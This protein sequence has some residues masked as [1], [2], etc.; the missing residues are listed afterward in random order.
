MDHRARLVRENPLTGGVSAEVTA[1]EVLRPDG[2]VVKLIVRRHGAVDLARNPNMAADEFRLLRLVRAHGVSAPDAHYVDDRCDLFP[3]P[4]IVIDYVEGDTVFD[5]VDPVAFAEQAAAELVKIHQIDSSADLAFLQ[6]ATMEVEA[7]PPLTD[8]GM[9]ETQ[10]RTALAAFQLARRNRPTLLHGDYWPGNWLWRG[11]RLAAIIDWEDAA[12]GDPLSD[13]GNCRFELAWLVGDEV[14]DLFTASYALRRSVDLSD[15]AYWDLRAALRP[16]GKL[17]A[18]GL[19]PE[20]ERRMR[21]RHA[22]FVTIAL[23]RAA[24]ELPP[25]QLVS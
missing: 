21:E 4:V 20:T 23:A 2:H 11:D 16:C 8:D 1:L 3:T 13:L 15:L 17:G 6:P 25:A 7:D 18:W 14:C 10:I 22:R 5:P 9:H 12:V 24:G 19:K